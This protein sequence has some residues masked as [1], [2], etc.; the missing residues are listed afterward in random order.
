MILNGLILSSIDCAR[1]AV[2]DPHSH[3]DNRAD[4][5][6]NKVR[7]VLIKR[8]SNPEGSYMSLV[9]DQVDPTLW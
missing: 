5:V 9:Y 3:L 8:A 6:E 7:Y 1:E 2:N 4:D